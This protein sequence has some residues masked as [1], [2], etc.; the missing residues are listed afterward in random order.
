MNNALVT[1]TDQLKTQE[2][3]HGPRLEGVWRKL[4]IGVWAFI[5]L[6][7]LIAFGLAVYTWMRWDSTP[8]AVIAQRDPTIT[9]E[10][11]QIAAAYQDAIHQAG[12]SLSFYG[13]LFAFL[14][15]VAGIP[16][17]VLSIL[18]VQRRNNRLMAVL[19]AMV[20]AVIGAAGRW[21]S[22]NWQPLPHFYS[23]LR[24]PILLLD[25]LLNCSVV[26]LYAF[27]DGRFVPRW[28]RW[29]A[30]VAVLLSFSSTVLANTPLDYT[31]L[32]GLWG[33][34]PSRILLA[35]GFFA[36]GYRYLRQADR[37]QRQQIK[38]IAAG[39]IPLAFFY[40]AHYL[41]YQTDLLSWLD[42]TPHLTFLFEMGLEPPW[43]LAQL[44]FAVCIGMAVLRYHLWDIDLVLN[45]VLVY[46]SLTLLT[47]ALYIGAVAGMGSLFRGV[48]DPVVFFLA[49]GLVAILFEPFRLRLQRL[50]NRL[51]YGER[52][53]PYAVLTRLY[54]TLEQ[55]ATPSETL[56]AIAI[57]MGQALKVPYLAL[58]ILQNGEEQ[59]AA[60]YG[61]PQPETIAFPIIYHSEQ[62]G[63]LRVARR[64][65]GE[66]FSSADLRLIENI[67]RQAGAAAQA[68]RLTSELIRSRAEIV[69]AREE[70]RRRLRRDLHDGL[71]PILASQT[72]KMA[73]VRQLVRQNPE[74]AETMVDDVIRQ[75]E[76]TVSEVRRLVYGLRPPALDEL[77]LVEAVRDLLRRGGQ[78]DLTASGLSVKV[79]SPD[80][81]LPRLPAAVEV[82]AYRIA[83]EALTNVA[84]HAQAR[85][86]E[87]Q[88]K[89]EPSQAEG[90]K[91]SLMVQIRDDGV[92]MPGTYR[93]GVGLRSMRER[94][95]EL[96][97]RLVIEATAPRGTQI[98]AW[99]PLIETR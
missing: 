89:Y 53:D 34:L 75:N 81:D 35:A 83:M 88:F 7:S 95:E 31:R 26:I 52:D 60:I 38:W 61:K 98:R 70:E 77:G 9:L 94:A 50:V 51:M 63:S 6:L 45:R 37:V 25:F 62:V 23:W 5:W 91:S 42:W 80:E 36:L 17:F 65:R 78:D 21:I 24:L 99:L 92:G 41:I 18:I 97:G 71:G 28:T 59:A 19:F 43:Y 85:N 96:G 2:R 4:G 27:P 82:N 16:Y 93:A 72:L 55:A 46:G 86:C 29:L 12:L 48:S 73:A 57:T 15:L 54:N 32:P 47:M 66:E 64:A 33:S 49:T 8:I 20:M 76:T 3:V 39:T 90:G 79:A 10:N 22:A 14:R 67:T 69:A 40:F 68:A 11:Q 84:R 1:P 74:R 56:P 44:I 13:G 87:I 30:A 58:Y